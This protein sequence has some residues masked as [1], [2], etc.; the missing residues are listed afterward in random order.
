[1]R[2]TRSDR[3][4]QQYSC[5]VEL[6]A[7]VLDGTVVYLHSIYHQQH[8]HHHNQYI[9]G[10]MLRTMHEHDSNHSSFRH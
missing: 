1:M 4:P 9:P 7:I 5:A 6:C 8:H 2:N 10:G 3:K